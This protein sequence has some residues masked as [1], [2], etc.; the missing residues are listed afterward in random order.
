MDVVER[1]WEA[2][3]VCTA[4]AQAATAREDD[5][6]A[7]RWVECAVTISTVASLMSAEMCLEMSELLLATDASVSCIREMEG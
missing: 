1:L 5:H 6:L 2:A 4:F 3:S 7:Q